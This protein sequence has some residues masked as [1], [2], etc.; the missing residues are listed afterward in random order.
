[1]R[2]IYILFLLTLCF[3]SACAKRNSATI[4]QPTNTFTAFEHRGNIFIKDQVGK[5]TRLTSLG[6]DRDPLI[7]PD[8][9]KLVFIRK[10]DRKAYLAIGDESDYIINGGSILADQIWMIHLATM[11]EQNLVMD[12]DFH[13]AEDMENIIAFISDLCFTLDSKRLYF[14][15]PCWATTSALH[16]VMLDTLK[17]KF[18]CP[19]GS[20]EVVQGGE[21]RGHL[22]VSKHKYFI[23][24]GSYDWY[25]LL[26]PEGK[27][28]GPICSSEGED[29]KAKIE[30]A[31]EL[32]S[33]I[34]GLTET[35]RAAFQMFTP[36]PGQ[37]I[38]NKKL[39]K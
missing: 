26:T 27:E 24:G 14:L 29:W 1:M 38:Q 39:N 4:Q 28:V 18:V 22:V 35:E 37:Y 9:N 16:V 5:V 11:K 15:T 21:Y 8:G 3:L 10:S 12:H 6:K 25:W 17:E 20:V 33:T 7:S 23:G 31:A 13:N 19:A 32:H 30:S 36:A 34:S 2:I